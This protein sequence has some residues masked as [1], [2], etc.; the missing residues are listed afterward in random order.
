M[1]LYY[2]ISPSLEDFSQNL[3]KGLVPKIRNS[4]AGLHLPFFEVGFDARLEGFLAQLS[5]VAPWRPAVGLG[6]CCR[7]SHRLRLGELPEM[8]WRLFIRRSSRRGV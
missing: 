4:A 2:S 5:S 7:F 6:S 1:V 8:Q 3:L